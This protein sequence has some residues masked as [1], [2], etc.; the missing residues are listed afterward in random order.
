MEKKKEATLSPGM[1][2]ASVCMAFIIHF[3]LWIV[4]IL[5]SYAMPMAGRV[6][7]VVFILLDFGEIFMG[8]YNNFS[9]FVKS[10]NK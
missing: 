3:I 6:A 1:A 10:S 9:R 2:L 7:L 4:V 8:I 5:N